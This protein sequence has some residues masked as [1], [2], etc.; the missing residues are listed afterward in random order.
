MQIPTGH[1]GNTIARRRLA[2]ETEEPDREP[3][4]QETNDGR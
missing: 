1:I 3:Q 2:L 4:K